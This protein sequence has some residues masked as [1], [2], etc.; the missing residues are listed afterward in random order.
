MQLS[1]KHITVVIPVGGGHSRELA[2]EAVE[3]I[4][5]GRM[6]PCVRV[7][8]EPTRSAS[9]NRNQ[10]AREALTEW[11]LFQDADDLMLGGTISR[12][13][14]TIDCNPGIQ[15]IVPTYQFNDEDGGITNY[16]TWSEAYKHLSHGFG[17]VM[18]SNVCIRRDLFLAMGGFDE[19]LLL[20][21]D[22]DL[23]CRLLGMKA[24]VLQ[25]PGAFMLVRARYSTSAAV[26]AKIVL[27][28]SFV[29]VSRRA[30]SLAY[31]NN[32]TGGW[33]PWLSQELA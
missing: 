20:M 25:M 26:K 19:T 8:S 13:E 27:A 32:P 6:L 7:V 3:A 29:E 15:A 9:Q 24:N 21:E 4:G 30:K 18:T 2:D 22:Y 17:L 10:G 28:E 1:S 16:G 33:I 31:I 11:V 12:L 14:D 5:R 23:A